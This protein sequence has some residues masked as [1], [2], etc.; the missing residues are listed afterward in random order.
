MK[1]TVLPFCNCM[2]KGNILCGPV[3]NKK[4]VFGWAPDECVVLSA[5]QGRRLRR[6]HCENTGHS[7]PPAK[8]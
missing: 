1:I 3:E 5:R 6:Q 7:W 8:S 4:E 2:H